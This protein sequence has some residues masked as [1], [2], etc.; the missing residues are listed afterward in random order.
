[1]IDLSNEELHRILSWANGCDGES[2]IDERDW[3]LLEKLAAATGKDLEVVVPRYARERKW[4]PFYGKSTKTPQE[5][6]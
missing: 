2:Y 5:R 4:R 1:M 3:P 6:Q